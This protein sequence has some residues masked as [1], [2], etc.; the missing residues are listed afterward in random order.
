ML[1][2]VIIF[3]YQIKAL[4]NFW[5]NLELN[6]KS[7]IQLSGIFSI[8]IFR[9]KILLVKLIKIHKL[10]LIN[11]IKKVKLLFFLKKKVKL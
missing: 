1:L 2:L 6:S 8:F 3:Y 10:L 5:C 4:I 9:R 7:F 11:I